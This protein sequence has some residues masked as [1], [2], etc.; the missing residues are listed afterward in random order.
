M[1][2]GSFAGENTLTGL[3]VLR[4]GNRKAGLG[5]RPQMGLDSHSHCSIVITVVA[6]GTGP[7][8]P[9][10]SG[11]ASRAEMPSASAVRR[12]DGFASIGFGDHYGIAKSLSPARTSWD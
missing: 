7:L 3:V 12:R 4:A 8:S 11:L 10:D 1:G 6:F 5:E 9:C 2:I